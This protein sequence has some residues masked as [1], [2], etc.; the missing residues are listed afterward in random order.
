MTSTLSDRRYVNILKLYNNYNGINL[1]IFD[2]ISNDTQITSNLK[3]NQ[4]VC[5][6]IC[7]QIFFQNRF[8]MNLY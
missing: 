5:L 6:R 4:S 3:H 8:Y 7:L 2:K 1:M